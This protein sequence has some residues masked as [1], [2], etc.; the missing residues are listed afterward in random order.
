MSDKQLIM[1]VNGLTASLRQMA[2]QQ[3]PDAKHHNSWRS[4]GYKDAL[5]FEDYWNMYMRLGLAK[6]L[7]R[8]PV[9]ECWRNLPT[10]DGNAAL[11][12]AIEEMDDR[13]GLWRAFRDV[14][15]RQGVGEYG[16]LFFEIADSKTPDQPNGRGELQAIKPL[17]QSQ[18]EPLDYITDP[19]NARYGQPKTWQIN[20]DAV[21]DQ[22]AQAG[23]SGKVHPDRVYVWAEG[24]PHGSIY[25]T[26]ALMAAFNSLVTA[27]KI[28]GAG[29]EGFWKSARGSQHI[30]FGD[31]DLSKIMQSLGVT[32]PTDIQEK[33]NENM[34]PFNTGYDSTFLTMGAKR[35]TIQITLPNPKEFFTVCLNDIAAS[36]GIP[37]TV[38]IGQQTGRLAS[39]EDQTQLAKMAT[40]RYANHLTPTIE[41]TI[42]HMQEQKLLPGGPFKLKWPDLFEPSL[43][44]KLDN[45]KRFAEV[46]SAMGREYDDKAVFNFLGLPDDLARAVVVDPE[47]DVS[48]LDSDMDALPADA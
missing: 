21:G 17:Y 48:E 3:T 1:A 24:A 37:G 25:G 15:E 45:L 8:L 14:D 39:D 26:P 9:D 33:V 36:R 32:K 30:D 7:V 13:I 29:G 23:R 12:K 28:L 5:G 4:Y 27:E 20:E 47:P 38:L 44:E 18:I 46:M 41:G 42:R 40:A 10:I 6:A 22:N 2:A 43:G 11:A 34:E 35:E 31:A 16:A 19:T